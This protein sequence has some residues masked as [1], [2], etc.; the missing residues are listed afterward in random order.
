M[1]MEKS[2]GAAFSTVLTERGNFGGASVDRVLHCSGKLAPQPF[3]QP[4][5][6]QPGINIM[7]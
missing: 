3:R 5:T 6:S 1:R 2:A 7:L 4:L